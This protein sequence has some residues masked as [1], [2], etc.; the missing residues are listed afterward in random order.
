MTD[1]GWQR[2]KADTTARQTWTFAMEH[3]TAKRVRIYR[4]SKC[5][6]RIIYILAKETCIKCHLYDPRLFTKK[7]K[8][9]SH[10]MQLSLWQ[11]CYAESSLRRS[12]TSHRSVSWIYDFILSL[13]CSARLSMF[14]LQ[15]WNGWYSICA[16]DTC[17]IKTIRVWWFIG[18][19]N[20]YV[21]QHVY[22]IYCIFLN[23]AWSV[24]IF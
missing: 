7:R 4:W 19:D 9:W 15:L 20:N 8:I 17:L 6:K 21:L 24:L 16:K 11:C 14:N 22:K 3:K 18:Q 10:D 2:K 23:I 5:V 1:T 13:F 12:V